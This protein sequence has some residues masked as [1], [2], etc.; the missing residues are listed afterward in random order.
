MT[1]LRR[2]MLLVALVGAATAAIGIPARTTHGAQVSI[3]EP[4]YLMTAIS[5]GEDLDLDISD[6]IDEKQYLPFHEIGLNTQTIDLN[7]HGQRLSPHDPL[8]PAILA[9]PMRLGGWVAARATLS[10]LA[11]ILAAATL[12][13]AVRRFG[14][15]V[16]T[17]G[18]V[19]GSLSATPPLTAYGS[20]VYP[21]LP[22]ALALVVA[23]SA[24]TGLRT[25]SEAAPR[26]RTLVV[27]V[28]ALTAL[29]WL[30]VKY[31]PATAAVAALAAWGL[32]QDGPWRGNRRRLLGLGAL[33][34]GAM[35]AAY[36]V[37]H[38]R[39]Y[40]GWTVYAAGDHFVDD[41]FGVVGF[42]PDY[43]GRTRRLVGLLVDRPFGL[44]AW[45]PAWLA[46]APAL[47][48]LVARRPAGWPLLAAPLAAGWAT[49]TWIALTMHGWWWPG[50]QVVVVLPLVVI[51][52]AL[53]V[54]RVRRSLTP[55]VAV[56][57]V[58]AAG[59]A[60]VAVE[61]ST[62]RRALAVDVTETAWLGYRWFSRLLPDLHRGSATD[63]WWA[64]AWAVLL[65][66][67]AVAAG[68]WATGPDPRL[69]SVEDDEDAGRGEGADA[70]ELA[71][72]LDGG[73]AVR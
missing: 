32:W 4:Q 55:L 50:R 37:L 25:G 73:G 71:G 65:V 60:W 30:S 51:T 2:A 41:E 17:G 11:G 59:W 68:R 9:M 70:H 43:W 67:V 38:L 20:Q 31:V 3:D 46:M 63:L 48:V 40:G 29:P 69:A 13:V 6:E 54:D 24:A 52:V 53:A 19:V 18:W 45:S 28:L 1:G 10:A 36:A 61:A 14:V 56:A 27:L 33:A 26:T 44:A 16:R 35:G 49:A 15:A 5:L 34:M 22:A 8:L 42:D 66:V 21:E 47:G 39:I 7:E 12:W 23:V 72:D 58:G 62:G 57:A 64:A